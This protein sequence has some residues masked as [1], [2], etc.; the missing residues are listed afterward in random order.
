LARDIAA[1]YRELGNIFTEF[2]KNTDQFIVKKWFKRN[3]YGG[4]NKGQQEKKP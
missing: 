1:K 2:K 4:N 3:D